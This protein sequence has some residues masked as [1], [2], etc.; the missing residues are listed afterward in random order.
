[1]SNKKGDR[2]DWRRDTMTPVAEAIG[3]SFRHT[4]LWNIWCAIAEPQKTKVLYRWANKLLATQ[5]RL[6]G[7]TPVR[8]ALKVL[9]AEIEDDIKHRGGLERVWH[10]LNESEQR[11]L[12]RKW[13][14]IFLRNLYMPEQE[15]KTHERPEEESEPSAE[16]SDRDVCEV[17]TD[18]GQ[19]GAQPLL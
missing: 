9:I 16:P 18:A 11:S 1:M 6:N 3:E 5:D 2:R 15:E 13:S 19:T 4:R 14:G 12:R 17:R 8:K 10:D 7:S